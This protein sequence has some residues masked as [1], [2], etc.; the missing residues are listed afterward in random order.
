MR[1]P[2]RATLLPG[3]AAAAAVAMTLGWLSAQIAPRG[4]I[5][6]GQALLVMTLA[7]LAGVA[8]GLLVRSRWVLVVVAIGTLVGVEV[9]RLDVHAASLAFR[10]DNAYG[11]IAFV[12]SRGLHGLLALLPMALGVMAGIGLARRMGWLPARTTRRL[13]IGSIVLVLLMVGLAVVVILPASTPPVVGRDG[14]PVPGSLAELTTVEL[15]G[16]PHAVLIRAADADAPVLLYLS[17][18]PGQSDLALARV[19]TS[20]WVEDLVVVA[21]D[22]RGNGKSYAA[23]DP[24]A[25]MTLDRA[26]DDVIELSEVIRDRF[27]EERIY[28]MG[29]SWGTLLGVLAVQRRPDLYHAWIGSGQMVDVAETDRGVYRDLVAYAERTADTALAAALADIGEP[30][31]RDLPWSNARVMGWYELLYEPFTPSPG[32]Q[33]RGEASG[34]DPF[35]MLGTEYGLMEKANVLRGLIDTFEQVYPQLYGFDLR[36]SVSRL[37]VPVWILDGAAELEARRSLALEWFD[38]LE[39][40]R[41]ELVTFE[42]AAHAVAFQQADEVQRLMLE[43]IIPATYES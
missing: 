10:F 32:Y 7:L 31:Y 19:L 17:G 15:G 30:P 5:T 12:A 20:G 18:G 25:D 41:K 36:E 11:I 2:E 27:D 40:P 37:D 14:Q 35:G 23:L 29:E 8:G 28:L 38:D 43:E 24:L 42:E 9:G 1:A 3:V 16:D 34:L 22:Q 33:A 39:A 13:P 26:V 4:P 21:F 6:T